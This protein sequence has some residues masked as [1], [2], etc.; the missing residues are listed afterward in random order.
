MV[1]HMMDGDRR[2]VANLDDV[3]TRFLKNED[4][5]EDDGRKPEEKIGPV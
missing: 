3:L 2:G 4:G 5:P 1:S